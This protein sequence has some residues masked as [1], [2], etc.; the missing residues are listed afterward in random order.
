MPHFRNCPSL[1][2]PDV[3]FF[4]SIMN[5]KFTP[6]IL[7]RPVDD[8]NRKN[9]FTSSKYLLPSIS[10]P[11]LSKG[12]GDLNQNWTQ[13]KIPFFWHFYARSCGVVL[14]VLKR[15]PDYGLFSCFSFCQR[16]LGS[17]ERCEAPISTPWTPSVML[18]YLSIQIPLMSKNKRLKPLNFIHGDL[19]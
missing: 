4:F 12:T 8:Y 2:N 3:A 13:E 9:S 1:Q 7:E 10:S 16:S 18:T 11:H 15:E 14:P 19:L 17:L 6:K 5:S